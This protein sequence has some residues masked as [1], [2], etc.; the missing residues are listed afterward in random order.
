MLDELK[1]N[2]ARLISL[3]ETE[4]QR[5]EELCAQLSE[6]KASEQA[7]REKLSEMERQI[8][9]LKLAQAF[10][11]GEKNLRAA[12]KIDKLIREID[13]CIALIED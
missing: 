9:N 13:K 2:I 1:Q 12:D 6:S 3:Y 10:A 5:N 7:C 4:K 11:G 8:E